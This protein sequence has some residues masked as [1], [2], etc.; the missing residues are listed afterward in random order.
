MT[1]LTDE[2]FRE[3]AAEMV[4]VQIKWGFIPENEREA[5]I[6]VWMKAAKRKPYVKPNWD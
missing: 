6:E 4:D 5:E 2:Q 3:F 1:Y